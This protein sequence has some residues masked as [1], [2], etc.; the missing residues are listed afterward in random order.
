[1]LPQSGI[2]VLAFMRKAGKQEKR[3]ASTSWFL[4][5]LIVPDLAGTDSRSMMTRIQ[6]VFESYLQ[7][8]PVSSIHTHSS[9]LTARVMREVQAIAVPRR[10]TVWRRVIAP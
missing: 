7:D 3:R 9:L 6:N 4:A 2:P 10:P 8:V 5:F 1:M